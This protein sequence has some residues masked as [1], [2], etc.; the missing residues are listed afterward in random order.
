MTD[1]EISNDKAR[2]DVDRIHAYLSDESYWGRGRPRES[3]ELGISTCLCFGAYDTADGRQL[4]F[5]RVLSDGV[6][7]AWVADVFSFPDA[8]G[9]GVGK[10]LMR[11]IADHPDLQKV[12]RMG[13]ITADAH[14]LYE[15]VGFHAPARPAMWMERNCAPEHEAWSGR[16]AYDD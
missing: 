3:T 8:R 11:A 7:M 14:G 15:S 2:L 13:L 10:A 16:W 6:V 5:A 12:K 9:R 4:G 1:I